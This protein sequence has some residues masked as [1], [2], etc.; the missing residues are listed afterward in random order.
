M[1]VDR[2]FGT[3][4][5]PASARTRAGVR[6]E[7]GVVAGVAVLLASPPWV[8]CDKVTGEGLRL[9]ELFVLEDHL[10]HHRPK[11]HRLVNRRKINAITDY[12]KTF[13]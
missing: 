8:C 11:P 5:V 2:A 9:L 6:H 3:D 13:T 7:V 1:L 10:Q 4:L 12:F